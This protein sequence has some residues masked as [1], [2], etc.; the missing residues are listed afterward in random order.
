MDDIIILREPS[1]Y[2]FFHKF[3][4]AALFAFISPLW[5]LITAGWV[6]PL[7]ILLQD[8]LYSIQPPPAV[9][10]FLFFSMCS[11][12]PGAVMA[13]YWT[14]LSG[15]RR[16]AA[17]ARSMFSEGD[18]SPVAQE[19]FKPD[20]CAIS[21]M[22]AEKRAFLVSISM[23]PRRY[24]N[25][26]G[27]IDDSD[28]IGALFF[29]DGKMFFHGDSTEICVNISS[30]ETVVYND[31]P[32]LAD[33]HLSGVEVCFEFKKK[34]SGCEG[35]SA[36]PLEFEDIPGAAAQNRIFS[37]YISDNILIP[38]ASPMQ[39]S[40]LLTAYFRILYPAKV[41]I[42][43]FLAAAGFSAAFWAN[44]TL[45]PRI[46][47]SGLE[48]VRIFS[49]HCFLNSLLIIIFSFAGAAFIWPRFPWA[50]GILAFIFGERFR[51]GQMPETGF[52]LWAVG[53]L[54]IAYQVYK[55]GRHGKGAGTGHDAGKNRKTI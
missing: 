55:D 5:F 17:M 43:W 6:P 25:F 14:S 46:L 39:G 3:K 16:N 52:S 30:V 22:I 28:D 50:F 21:E 40:G 53:L 1:R 48:S 10:Y 27:Y 33:Y 9:F 54:L 19:R 37:D 32:V 31:M 26:E 49:L 18:A 20:L 29:K 7:F 15:E 38:A 23:R 11:V 45:M 2:T 12:P 42:C 51:R 8:G 47:T 24:K 35:F 36:R 13:H 44:N 41:F 4:A 34:I